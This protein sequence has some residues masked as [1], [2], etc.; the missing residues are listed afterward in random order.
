NV[1]EVDIHQSDPS[2]P[3]TDGDGY[4]D[5]VEVENGSDPLDENS[6][7]TDK[8]SYYFLGLVLVVPM[9]GVIYRKY[10]R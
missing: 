10:K 6:I 8:S 3:D 5:G 1:E 7:P 2:N 9:L 4:N